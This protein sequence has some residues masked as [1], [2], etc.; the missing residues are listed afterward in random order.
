MSKNRSKFLASH[1]TFDDA[2]TRT[3]RWKKNRCAAFRDFFDI[4]NGNCSRHLAPSEYL[5]LDETLYPMR[6]HVSFKQYN[7]NKPAK[8]GVLFKS[9][10]DAR[11]SYTYRSLVYAGKPTELPSP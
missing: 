4:F 1:L 6:N 2:C 11:Y 8:Y 5:S 10:N 9:L 7:P 3:Q